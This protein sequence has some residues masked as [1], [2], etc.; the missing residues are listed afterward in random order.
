[1]SHKDDNHITHVLSKDEFFKILEQ[2][3]NVIVK[4]T[5]KWCGPCKVIAPTFT[6]LSLC[7]PDIFFVEI[8]IDNFEELTTDYQISGIPAFILFRQGKEI[9]RITGSSKKDL[10]NLVHK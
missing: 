6:E 7:C 3:N 1:M 4:F 9:G 5:A 10:E 2:Q 8:D